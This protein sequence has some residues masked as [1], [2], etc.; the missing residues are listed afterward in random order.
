[1]AQENMIF[2]NIHPIPATSQV[3]LIQEMSS[4]VASSSEYLLL[5]NREQ[6]PSYSEYGRTEAWA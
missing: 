4:S 5:D 2:V 3:N 6:Y 1:M